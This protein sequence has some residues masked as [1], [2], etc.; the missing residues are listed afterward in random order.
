MRL[1]AAFGA[2]WLPRE[3]PSPR[4]QEVLL[5]SVCAR[6]LRQRRRASSC[7]DCQAQQL[8][9]SALRLQLC[10]SGCAF[11]AAAIPSR[12]IVRLRIHSEKISGVWHGI[13]P[14]FVRDFLGL[15][16]SCRDEDLDGA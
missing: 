4:L 7:G 5:Q 15:W 8:S 3:Q 1:V 12:S 11:L 9:P 10:L 16:A 14:N 6:A 2:I 13:N